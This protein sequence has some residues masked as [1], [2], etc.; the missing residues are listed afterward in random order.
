MNSA[1]IRPDAGSRILAGGIDTHYHDQGDGAPV[2]LLHGSGPGVSAWSNW[3]VTIAGLRERFRMI[4]PE[5]VGYGDTERPQGIRYGVRTWVAHVL[6]FLDAL[7]LDKV[8]IVG[9]S[10]GGLV[11]LHIAQRW[12]ERVERMVLMGAP[13]PEMTPS[14]GL[15]AL[16]AYE[17]SLDAMRSLLVDHFAFDSAVVTEELVR[18]RFEASNAP[19]VHEAYKGM[20][21][22][23]RHTGDSLELTEVGVRGITVPS[24]VMHGAHDKI[25]PVDV[26]WRLAQLIPDCDAHIFARCGH[27]TQ[28]ERAVDFNRIVGDFLDGH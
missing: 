19:G 3:S 5:M 24:L 28:I 17:P 22:D 6:D 9:N 7:G 15:L 16:R 10:M 23:S 2:V 4:A 13:A 27:W 12:P 26:G 25:I 1:A 8:S 11:A 20:F 21:R 18:S 14:E